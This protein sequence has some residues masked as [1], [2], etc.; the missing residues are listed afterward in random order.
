MRFTLRCR[1]ARYLKLTLNYKEVEFV[2]GRSQEK[3]IFSATL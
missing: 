1:D 2:Q 3:K